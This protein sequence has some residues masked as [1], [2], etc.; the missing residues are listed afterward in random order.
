MTTY[1]VDY[2]D[3]GPDGLYG[4][5]L[6]NEEAKI[7]LFYT[8]SGARDIPFLTCLDI[9]NTPADVDADEV[10]IEDDENANKD[11]CNRVS[12]TI[13]YYVREHED[14]KFVVVSTKN[15]YVSVIKYIVSCNN[16]I[17][18]APS[19][20]VGYDAMEGTDVI[21]PEPEEKPEPVGLEE[22]EE[23]PEDEI[24]PEEEPVAEEPEEESQP[25]E[26]PI[27]EEPVEEE[28]PQNAQIIYKEAPKQDTT[29]NSDAK[30]VEQ[31][32]ESEHG[33]DLGFINVDDT[34]DYGQSD[35]SYQEVEEAPEEE[36]QPAP[37]IIK[38]KKPVPRLNVG[39]MHAKAIG[40]IVEQSN[41]WDEFHVNLVNK[42][43]EKQAADFESKV[44]GSLQGYWD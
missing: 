28:I 8:K 2:D 15:D 34:D 21:H 7:H 42:Y 10:I 26:E 41:S 30:F 44:S 27:E 1:F 3:V 32:E 43:G 40:E 4:I 39:F 13:G 12:A 38:E 36:A 17:L 9:R 19:I 35:A 25:E 6:L 16:A 18:S 23:A 14:E 24:I 33:D 5:K 11:Y 20:S 22:V 37:V 31:T 29:I